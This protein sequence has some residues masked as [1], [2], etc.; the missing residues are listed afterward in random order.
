[1]KEWE[2]RKLRGQDPSG[3]GGFAA[4]RGGRRHNGVDYCFLPDEPVKSPVAGIVTRIGQCYAGDPTY[5]LVE[6]LSDKGAAMWRF[7]YVK[8]A[9][10]SAQI[11]QIGQTIGTAQDIS[12]RYS[13]NMKNHVHVEVNLD[14]ARVLG[15][16][17]DGSEE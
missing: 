2:K 12:R 3:D 16:V 8:P 11:V 6:I 13:K 5:K 17:Q 10:K 9:V 1:M 14:V 4:P 7:L 15:G